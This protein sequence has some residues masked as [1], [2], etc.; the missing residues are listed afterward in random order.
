MKA[1]IEMFLMYLTGNQNKNTY[2]F[3]N[4]S[5]NNIHVSN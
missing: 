4:I 3:F 1:S 2:L 5:I